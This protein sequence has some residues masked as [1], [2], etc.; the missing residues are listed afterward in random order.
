MKYVLAGVFAAILIACG[1]GKKADEQ[2]FLN[3]ILNAIQAMPDGGRL[4]ITTRVAKSLRGE[5]PSHI[6]IEF[7]DSGEGMTAEQQQRAFTSL[8]NT[9]KNAGTGLGLAIV[10]RVVET[11]RGDIQI[12][13]RPGHGTTMSVTLPL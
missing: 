9:T 5:K 12:K 1:S 3:L 4:T 10:K 11:H 13:S 7:K 8:L 2:A 6:I